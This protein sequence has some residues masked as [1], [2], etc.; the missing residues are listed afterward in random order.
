MTDALASHGVLFATAF[1]AATILPGSSEVLL[2]ALALERPQDI[3]TLFL[4]ATVG[5]TAGSG[6][7][8]LLGRWFLHFR[9]R[10]WFPASPQRLASAES[11]F[12]KYGMWSLVFA[13]VPIVGDAL[14]VIA[15]ALHVNP[16]AFTAL[17]GVGKALRYGAV[18]WGSEAVHGWLSP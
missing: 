17:V 15:G 12:N 18:L 5:N 9:D 10:R 14:T 13:W 16:Y 11:W 3:T 8:W 7:N 4:A 6:V 1:L 2:I